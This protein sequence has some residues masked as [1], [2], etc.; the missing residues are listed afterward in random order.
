M[1]AKRA[2][3]HWY[4]GE[5]MEE[6]RSRTPALV[7]PFPPLARSA[8]AAPVLTRALPPTPSPRRA[9]SPRPART[10]PPSRRTTRRSAPSPP[11]AR[12]RMRARSTKH[13]ASCAPLACP[14]SRPV[15]VKRHHFHDHTTPP[16]KRHPASQV[17]FTTKPPTRKARA[18]ALCCA[19]P[20]ARESGVPTPSLERSLRVRRR[21]QIHTLNLG[22]ALQ[23][24]YGV[25]YTGT[26]ASILCSSQLLSPWVSDIQSPSRQQ[27]LPPRARR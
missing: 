18:R 7:P 2:F 4:V 21:V 14:P 26:E 11:R 15:R 24:Y 12:A 27:P 22:A 9:S 5:G 16:S 10:S 20:R 3:V 17:F 13:L 19:Q 23:R 8:H 6:V 25:W 1:Y